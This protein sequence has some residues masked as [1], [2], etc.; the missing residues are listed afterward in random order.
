LRDGH[1]AT[2]TAFP[3]EHALSLVA[4]VRQVGA[5]AAVDADGFAPNPNAHAL[6]PVA[7]RW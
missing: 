7:G 5:R 2:Q 4:S 1:W 3:T 6:L